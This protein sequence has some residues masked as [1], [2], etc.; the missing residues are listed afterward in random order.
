LFDNVHAI[1]ALLAAA[2]NDLSSVR[3]VLLFEQDLLEGLGRHL[4]ATLL[5]VH[6][7][8][9]YHR[10]VSRDAGDLLKQARQVLPKELLSGLS[11]AMRNASAHLDFQVDGDVVVLCPGPAETRAT[12]EVFGDLALMAAETVYAVNLA[13]TCAVIQTGLDTGVVFDLTEFGIAPAAAQEALLVAHGWDNPVI[14]Y[15]GGVLVAHGGTV[16]RSPMSIVGSLLPS[17]PQEVQ[18]VVLETRQDSKRD[19]FSIGLRALR[20]RQQRQLVGDPDELTLELDFLEAC[21]SAVIN[22]SPFISRNALR[23]Y[24]AIRAGERINGDL[25]TALAR[26]RQLREFA[27]AIDDH[28]CAEVLRMVVRAVR[29]NAQG[30]PHDAPVR[31][32]LDEVI[33]WERTSYPEPFAMS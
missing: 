21:A 12:A 8:R 33:R 2:R 16:L 6:K 17:M 30:V 5:A 4:I 29:L 32:A 27:I 25:N 10:L 20:R 11:E 19:R 31:A 28:H 14:S 26:L 7:G 13:L 3:A 18:T 22:G 24:I 23:H 1:Q 9:D 15:D